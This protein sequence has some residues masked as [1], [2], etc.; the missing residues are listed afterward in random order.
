MPLNVE[1]DPV[2]KLLLSFAAREILKF[3]RKVVRN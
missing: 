2:S 1:E 3:Q